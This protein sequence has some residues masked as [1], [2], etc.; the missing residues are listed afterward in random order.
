VRELA[1]FAL[2]NFPLEEG[3]G[4]ERNEGG[5][6]PHNFYDPNGIYREAWC[7]SRTD[8]PLFWPGLLLVLLPLKA[9]KVPAEFQFTG[10]FLGDEKVPLSMKQ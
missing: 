7:A 6:S 10:E 1:R 5:A 4:T 9:K 2:G 3:K 8:G